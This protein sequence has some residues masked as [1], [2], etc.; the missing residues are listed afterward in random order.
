MI[1]SGSVDKRLWPV[2]G[3][4]PTSVHTIDPPN[5]GSSEWMPRVWM[6]ADSR[7]L[8]KL[9]ARHHFDVGFRY[10][11][12]AAFD[13]LVS[14][15]NSALGLAEHA[16]YGRR[17]RRQ[18]IDAPLFV[19]GHWRCGSTLLHELLALDDRHAAP[20][21]Y[22]VSAAHHCVLTR[23]LF[24][25]ILKFLV[26]NRRPMDEMP[27]SFDS[28]S[29]DEFAICLLGLRSPYEAI[30][31]PNHGGMRREQF[32]PDAMTPTERS[33]WRRAFLRFLQKVSLCHPGR[34]LV[35]KSPPHTCRIR[36]ILS[37]FP[38]A[39]FVLVVRNPYEVFVSTM[40]LWRTLFRSQG[41]QQPTY[42]GLEEMV[43]EIGLYLQECLERD[44][45]LIA[46]SR[47]CCVRFDDLVRDPIA[48][49]RRVY[50]RL[51][52]GNFTSA[53]PAAEKYLADRAGYR[54]NQY[55]RDE[56]TRRMIQTRW[57]RMFQQWGYDVE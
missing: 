38:D 18:R 6:G 12:I 16:I 26:P 17:I 21:A 29:E 7:A 54:Q 31:F 15:V 41:L 35:L 22:E 10:W 53:Q 1:L 5:D 2:T 40:H 36:T 46:D 45:P 48:E 19:I 8:L 13:A 33:A 43:L 25:R 20:S 27:I 55:Q 11:Y 23:R 50:S 42:R 34:R 4:I 57:A 3:G 28:P 37:L 32:D 52:C 24:P 49:M 47:F 30:A 51:D 14:P 9:L 39:R 56:E 44:R